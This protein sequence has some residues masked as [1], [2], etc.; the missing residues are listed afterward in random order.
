LNKIA[1]LTTKKTILT[2]NIEE[3]QFGEFENASAH[4]D[5]Q[6]QSKG[7]WTSLA[8][9]LRKTPV[10]HFLK[11]NTNN[12]ELTSSKGIKWKTKLNTTGILDA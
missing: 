12:N 2:I 9:A 3:I 4:L 7:T 8:G 10:A 1:C 5:E 6:S 11:K